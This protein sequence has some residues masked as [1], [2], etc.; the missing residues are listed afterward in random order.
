MVEEAGEKGWI[1]A[2]GGVAGHMQL[3][4]TV[5]STD[6]T[7]I[8]FRSGVQRHVDLRD[9]STGERSKTAFVA[10][11]RSFI[12]V[13]PGR[14]GLLGSRPAVAKRVPFD[15]VKSMAV[16]GRKDD[17]VINFEGGQARLKLSGL[18]PLTLHE[19]A[20]GIVHYF[21]PFLPLRLQQD[22]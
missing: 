6:E 1:D 15:E 5:A 14:R 9:N 3:L 13:E 18:G 17:L 20:S 11:D 12:F 22:W 2:P 7:V 16:D 4:R 10:T 21:K 19:R 8:V